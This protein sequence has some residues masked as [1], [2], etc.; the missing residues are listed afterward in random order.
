VFLELIP[1][2]TRALAPLIGQAKLFWA[3]AS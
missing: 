1:L 2:T 3:L